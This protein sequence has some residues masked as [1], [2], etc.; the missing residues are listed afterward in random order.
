MRNMSFA[1]TTEQVRNRTKTV[2]RRLGWEFL[3]PGDLVRA[4]KQ[5]QGLK[6]GEK[7]EPLAV[8][9]V[10]DVRREPLHYIETGSIVHGSAEVTKEG[11]PHMRCDDFVDF[12]AESHRCTPYDVVTRIEFEYV[13]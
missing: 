13:D 2:T 6:K 3:K 10:V 12:F 8:L 1:L 9:R 5:C 11:F 4:V 7:V